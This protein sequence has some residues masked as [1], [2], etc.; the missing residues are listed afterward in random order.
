MRLAYQ[1]F[2]ADFGVLGTDEEFAALNGPPLFEIIDRLKAAHG[3]AEAPARLAERYEAAI[4]D[5]Y[6]DVAPAAGARE[7]LSALQRRGCKIG[8]VTS[9]DGPLTNT[10]L[11]TVGLDGLVDFVVSSDMI[12]RGKP[13]PEPYLLAAQRAACAPDS[14][15]AVED[16]VTGARAARAAGIATFL[17]RP[18]GAPAS[19]LDVTEIPSLLDV[20]RWLALD[21]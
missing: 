10:W 9:N 15:I 3:L 14:I 12:K 11:A 16:S 1:R 21:E 20:T 7:L 18:A 2:L 5:A 4:S 8:I 13:D 6:L 19:G 17:L